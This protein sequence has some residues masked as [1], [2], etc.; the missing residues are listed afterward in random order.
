MSDYLSRPAKSPPPKTLTTEIEPPRNNNLLE[1]PKSYVAAGC[2]STEVI[3]YM[4]QSARVTHTCMLRNLRS[5][6]IT[7]VIWRSSSSAFLSSCNCPILSA[8]RLFILLN[9]STTFSKLNS[10]RTSFCKV[11]SSKSNLE[12]TGSPVIIPQAKQAIKK[13]VKADIVNKCNIQILVTKLKRSPRETFSL[14]S[15]VLCKRLEEWACA[16]SLMLEVGVLW[17]TSVLQY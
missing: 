15:S 4:R 2:R 7:C 16:V 10:I 14:L 6:F 5:H 12:Q 9:S 17:C 3:Q 11:F 1:Q 8:T 13:R